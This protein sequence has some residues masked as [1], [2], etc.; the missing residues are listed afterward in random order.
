ML[1]GP[2]QDISNANTL[3]GGN[4]QPTPYDPVLICFE[5]S[6]TSRAKISS[7]FVRPTCCCL[8]RND[9]CGRCLCPAIQYVCLNTTLEKKE[10]YFTVI[11]LTARNCFL[12]L[13]TLENCG[14]FV[15][16]ILSSRVPVSYLC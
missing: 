1:L 2:I 13:Q 11:L 9:C 5:P 3:F 6:V 12:I 4:D 8:F 15:L 7:I 10:S 14:I 16:E